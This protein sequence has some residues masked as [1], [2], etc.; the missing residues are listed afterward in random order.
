MSWSL[1]V[2]A[3]V[4]AS[5]LPRVPIRITASP[6]S[7][8]RVIGAVAPAGVEFRCRQRQFARGDGVD[9]LR[10][11][12][13]QFAQRLGVGVAAGR[14]GQ[15]LDPHRRACSSL[16]TTWRTVRATSTL[17]VVQAGQPVVQPQQLGLDDVGGALAQGGDGG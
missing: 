2:P 9:G 5:R 13:E 1:M 15:L 3:W 11:E 8:K 17:A 7:V 12:F 16:S 4:V 6:P 10:V 14:T